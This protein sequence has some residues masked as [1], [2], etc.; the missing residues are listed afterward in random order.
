MTASDQE[1]FP[2]DAKDGRELPGEDIAP[3]DERLGGTGVAHGARGYLIG[4]VLAAGLTEASFYF[5]HSSLV[6]A[7]SIP[8]LLIVLAI[9][10]MG[11]HLVFFL[12]ITTGPDNT[13]NVLALAFGVLIVFL[14]IAGSIW[15]MANLDAHMPTMNQVMDMQR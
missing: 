13:N 2:P 5:A 11:V 3:G 1:R 4:F 14:I 6:W 7:P 8:E 15:I 12:H 10:Q 9:A